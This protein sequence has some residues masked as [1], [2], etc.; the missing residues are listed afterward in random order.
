MKNN[1]MKKSIYRRTFATFL[2][3]YLLLMIAFSVFLVLEEKKAVNNELVLNAV[4]ISNRI[5]EIL[6]DNLDENNQIIDIS[7]VKKEFVNKQ[8]VISLL[9]VPEIALFTRDYELIYNTN[10]YWR[11]AYFVYDG[12]SQP[13]RYGLLNPNDWFNEEE[14]EE[15]ENYFYAMPN[16]KKIGDLKNY[17]L[18]FDGYILED[19]MLV[20]NNLYITPVY[21]ARFDQQ[22]NV[23]SGDGHRKNAFV[24]SSGYENIDNLP[25]FERG[26]PY[27]RYPSSDSQNHEEL[28]QIVTNSSKLEESIKSYYETSSPIESS[29]ISGLTYRYYMMVPYESMITVID[30]AFH[31]DFWA[32]V[33]IDINIGERISSTLIYVWISCLLIFIIASY[34]LSRQ[35]YKT[36]LKGEELERQRKE[37]TDA[38]AHDLKTPLSIISGYAQN[39]QENIH[40]EKRTDYAI[41]INENIDRMDNIIRQMLDMSKIESDSFDLKLIDISFAEMSNEIVRRYSQICGDKN[42]SISVEGDTLVKADR[43]LIER[44]IDNFIINALDNTP[45]D[46]TINI[47]I[48]SDKFEI[49][50]SGSQ[51]PENKVDEIWLPYKKGNP[52]REA[53]KGTGLG[54]SISRRILELH[55]FSYGASNREDG[56]VFWFK[57]M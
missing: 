53:S 16:P 18:T 27:P 22:G 13:V 25:Y 24:Y 30:G 31:S 14:I 43:S 8:F 55:K 15:I 3:I 4:R 40:T 17:S 54:L 56:V 50:N 39:I 2:A 38:L 23:V 34:I 1:R 6:E 10:D 28:R 9:D 49:Y 47:K 5:V 36:H 48:S 12:D 20:P 57:W 32:A 29:R 41:H 26:H 33:G 44:V 19:E 11:C 7:K 45:E 21:A 42:I 52:E 46:G 35:T 37:M 51:I